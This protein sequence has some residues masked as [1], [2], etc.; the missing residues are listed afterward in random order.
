MEFPELGEHCAVASCSRL[1]FLPFT[2]DACQ[3]VF[4][5][6]HH[7]YEKH[8]CQEAYTKNVTVPVCPLCNQPVPIKR[9][10]DPNVS[11]DEHIANDC[12]SDKAKKAYSNKCR[13]PGCKKKELVPVVCEH[14]GKNYCLRHRFQDDH[15]CTA[16]Q[17]ATPKKAHGSG[18]HTKPSPVR[19]TSSGRTNRPP[20]ATYMAQ[21]GAEMNRLRME[22][23]H[24]QGGQQR[25]A[26]NQ[27]QQGMGEDE[28][29]AMAMA[30]SLGQTK[31]TMQ[32]SSS[33][34]VAS[35]YDEDEALARAV[36]ASLQEEEKE[37]QAKQQSQQRQRQQQQQ[38]QQKKSG[39]N[40][41]V[42]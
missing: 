18:V 17:L 33:Q 27:L 1:D 38:Q 12:Q 26:Y 29:L 30:A 41:S 2:C 23:R 40:C 14:C 8:D 37:K 28:A 13:Y 10:T 4:C 5:K 36:A 25:S 16:A 22:R 15:N 11:V 9:G 20:Q 7:Q 35:G 6:D 3:K 19:Q 24:Q 32:P 21:S 39:D 42:S 31:P 34:S